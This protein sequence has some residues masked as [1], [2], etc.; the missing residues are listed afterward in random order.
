MRRTMKILIVDDDVML[1]DLLEAEL[2]DRGHEIC[3]VT[4]NVAEAVNLV[5][6]HRPDIAVLDM[7]LKE[8]ELGSDIAHQLAEAGDLRDLGILYV[9]GGVDFLHQH[10]G[11]GHACLQKPYS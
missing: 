9:T 2:L 3:G 4:T 10:A 8:T 6:L 11:I 7:K 1:A 5:R